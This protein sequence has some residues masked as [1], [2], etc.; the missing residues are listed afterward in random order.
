MS[1]PGTINPPIATLNFLNIMTKQSKG[2]RSY[3]IRDIQNWKFEEQDFPQEWLKHLGNVPNRFL[4]YVDGDPG[5]GKTEYIIQL[6]KM[7]AQFMGKVHVNNVEQGKHVQIKDS[8]LRNK[9]DT[10]VKRG[11]WMYSNIRDFEK[12]EEKLIKRGSGPIQIIDS[13]SFWPL[14]VKQVQKLVD[15][16]RRKSFIFVGYKAHFTTNKPIIH[17]CDIKVRVEK[18]FAQPVSRYG[19]N[20]MFDIWPAKHGNL[21]S[22]P[23]I[24]TKDFEDVEKEAT[25]AETIT[26]TE[27]VQ[28]KLLSDASQAD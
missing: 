17:M 16:H 7:L 28:E 10:E 12:Y 23:E 8:L 25:V 27:E 15:L 5:N 4:M 18:F 9:F 3:G 26:T 11:K 14:S 21:F 22:K 1:S 6:S 20:E 19:G 2:V 24:D 13:I